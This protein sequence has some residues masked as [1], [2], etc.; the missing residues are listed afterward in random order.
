[1]PFVQVA[2]KKCLMIYF[3]FLDRCFGLV[4]VKLQTWFPMPLQVYVNGHEWLARKLADCGVSFSKIDNVF[5]HVE[6]LRRAQ[7]FADRFS[8]LFTNRRA[9]TASSMRSLAARPLPA[10]AP[11][12]RSTRSAA[13]TCSCSTL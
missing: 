7:R 2:H 9:L 5:T 4:H 10:V 12:R 8:S 3:Y 6:D 11:P 13:T 1:M